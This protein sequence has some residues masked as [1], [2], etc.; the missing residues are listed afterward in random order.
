ME[1]LNGCGSSSVEATVN[2]AP[3]RQRCSAS[4]VSR[5]ATRRGPSRAARALAISLTAVWLAACGAGDHGKSAE[6]LADA[7]RRLEQGDLQA[8]IIQLRN[9]VAS[10]PHNIEPQFQL[11]LAE[12]Q[13]GGFARAETAL[14]AARAG[15][16]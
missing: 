3:R 2:P 4:L 10:D 9:A 8:A 12:L 14:K 13:A 1:I 5:L 6:F 11:G 15:G 16:Y 7:Q